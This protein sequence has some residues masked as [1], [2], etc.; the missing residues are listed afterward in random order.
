MSFSG[1]IGM[2]LLLALSMLLNSSM[3]LSYSAPGSLCRYVLRPRLTTLWATRKGLSSAE[4]S[5]GTA[6]NDAVV[7]TVS[8]AESRNA[9]TSTSADAAA[10]DDAE[11]RRAQLTAKSLAAAAKY[12]LFQR[13]NVLIAGGS[14]F[15][16][17]G[18][19]AFQRFGNNQLDGSSNSGSIGRDPLALLRSM[20]ADSIPLAVALA[21]GKPT[22][23]DFY[24][25][26]CENC[27]VC[28]NIHT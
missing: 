4:S 8:K 9:A 20:E 28:L 5:A 18:I 23:I 3:S 2:R 13:R 19:F 27:K 1:F 15:A 11:A 26:W 6:T 22:V 7:A 24:A 10:A 12:D 25:G 16:G 17:A 14:A 21:N